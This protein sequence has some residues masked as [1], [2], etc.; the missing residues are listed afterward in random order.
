MWWCSAVG[1]II[2][3]ILSL[4][5]APLATEA[6]P[7][8]TVPRI[9]VL[10]ESTLTASSRHRAAFLQGLHAL[11]YVEG[12]TIVLEERW[13]EGKL[14]RLPDL[15]AELVQLQV[16]VIVAGNPIAARAASQATARLP[17]VLAGGDV[18]GTGLIANIARPGGNITGVATNVAELS[19]KWLELLKEAMPATSRVAVLSFPGRPVTEPALQAMQAAALALGVQLQVLRVRDADE[20]EGAFAA[21]SRE[22]AEALV[23]LP[24]FRLHSTRILELAARS[25]LPTMW[26]DREA[27]ADGGLM[28]YGTDFA[29]LWQRAA[30]YVDKILKGAPPGNLPVERP[31]SFTLVINLKTAKALGL[32][33]PPSLLLLADEV[34][35]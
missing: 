2:T 34:I 10:S 4:L 9:G 14:E 7:S 28:G 3:L 32:T 16:H 31:M 29:S 35:Q 11:G 24:G 13:A 30:T 6:Q 25:R 21:M 12:Q 18:V 5:M 19:A 33:M 15:A 23:V 1:F 17:I 20:L 8:P 27:V 22:H 26:E